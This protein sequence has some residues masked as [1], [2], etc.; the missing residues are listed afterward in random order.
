MVHFVILVVFPA[1]ALLALRINRLLLLYFVQFI[2]FYFY[3]KTLKKV[4]L[5][6]ISS[7]VLRIIWALNLEILWSLLKYL[8]SFIF[9]NPTLKLS[10]V[11]AKAFLASKHLL[12]GSVIG[13]KVH[14]IV[15]KEHVVE[16]CKLPVLSGANSGEIFFIR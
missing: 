16:G 15:T 6:T 7:K 9:Y 5:A 11:I 8:I 10:K 13:L 2:F 3:R 14:L 1:H 4:L 12:L